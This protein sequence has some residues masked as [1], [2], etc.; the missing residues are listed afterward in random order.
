MKT[1][2]GNLKMSRLTTR[3]SVSTM[4]N[5]PSNT[6]SGMLNNTYDDEDDDTVDRV[7]DLQ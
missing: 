1:V 3:T 5:E 4:P 2:T 7:P 6:P